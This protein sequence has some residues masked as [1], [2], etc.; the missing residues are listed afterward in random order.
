VDSNAA[1]RSGD[2]VTARRPRPAPGRA[3]PDEGRR[4]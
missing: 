1:S 2:A 4:A 3:V